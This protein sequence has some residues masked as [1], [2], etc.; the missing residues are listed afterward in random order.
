[1][2]CWFNYINDYNDVL[3]F[4]NV[5]MQVLEAAHGNDALLKQESECMA[6]LKAT[7]VTYIYIIVYAFDMLS[8]VISKVF[9][10]RNFNSSD[11][12]T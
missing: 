5:A 6:A 3:Q 7:I 11:S 4:I 9:K 8:L 12:P 2:R 10:P 1:M